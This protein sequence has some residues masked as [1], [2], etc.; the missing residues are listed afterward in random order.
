MDKKGFQST[1]Q[2]S[3]IKRS[4]AYE[5]AARTK[6]KLGLGA[7]ALKSGLLNRMGQIK[8]LKFCNRPASSY[9]YAEKNHS[10]FILL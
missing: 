6:E 1:T 10:K 7:Q 8:V 5:T 4:T 2:I 9:V 3:R